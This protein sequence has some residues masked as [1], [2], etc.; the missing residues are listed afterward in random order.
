MTHKIDKG[1]AKMETAIHTQIFHRNT[2]H[3]L[4]GLLF[5]MPLQV[6]H[7]ISYT[8]HV[9]MN[10]DMTFIFNSRLLF[11]LLLLTARHPSRGILLPE[12]TTYE[13]VCQGMK[14]LHD[15]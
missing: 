9:T 8:P 14:I 15:L 1:E 11:T 12:Y 5:V 2:M 3:I 10:I 7:H 6:E 4:C 13:K